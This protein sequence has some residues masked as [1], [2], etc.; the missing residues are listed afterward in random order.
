MTKNQRILTPAFNCIEISS[1]KEL[2]S[3]IRIRTSRINQIR[4][5]IQPLEINADP[6]PMLFYLKIHFKYFSL[7][8]KSVH[9]I[10]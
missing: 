10:Y 5:R 1:T 3:R 6:D 7:D 2:F 4:I 9:L 8:I